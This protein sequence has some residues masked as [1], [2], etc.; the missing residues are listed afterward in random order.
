MSGLLP[1]RFHA[2]NRN[3]EVAHLKSG[4]GPNVRAVECNHHWATLDAAYPMRGRHHR[5]PANDPRS[6]R[7]HAGCPYG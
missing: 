7:D 5:R 1:L 3:F 6:G 2:P 4:N